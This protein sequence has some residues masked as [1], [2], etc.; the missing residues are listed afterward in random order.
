M[1][2]FPEDVPFEVVREPWCTYDIGDDC[3]LRTKLVILKIL[4]PPGIPLE[5]VKGLNFPAHVHIAVDA[6][7]E[8]KGTPETK[9]LTPE[10]LRNSIVED[11]D[12]IPIKTPKNEYKLKNGTVIRFSLSLT[13]VARTD[14]FSDDGSPVFVVSHQIV[15]QLR[16]PKRRKSSRRKSK[17]V[18]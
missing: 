10:L 16:F 14:L 11:I 1:S 15:P 6:P 7:P 2:L 8:K 13:R 12:P 9:K 4:K 18:V 5:K 17:G 3:T